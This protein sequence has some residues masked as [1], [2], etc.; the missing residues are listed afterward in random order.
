[1][2]CVASFL[3]VGTATIGLWFGPLW[4]MPGP[5]EVAAMAGAAFGGGLLLIGLSFARTALRWLLL[6]AGA[7]CVAAAGTFCFLLLR[8]PILAVELQPVVATAPEAGRRLR[9]LELD[10]T[11]HDPRTTKSGT[12]ADELIERVRE[13][14]PDVVLVNGVW[15]VLEGADL[16]QELGAA[17]GFGSAYA[18]AEGSRRLLG[19]ERGVA[20]LS[21]FPLQAVERLEA[22]P[23]DFALSRPVA[24]RAELD[25]GGGRTGAVVAAGQVG[26][27]GQD[28]EPGGDRAAQHLLL[29]AAEERDWSLLWSE[30]AS[31]VGR[32]YELASRRE[33]GPGRW[34]VDWARPDAEA[35]GFDTA[36]LERSAARIGEMQGVKGLIVL[37]H[38]ELA[39][40]RYFRDADPRRLHNLKSASKSV[41]SAIAGIAIEEGSLPL[42][43]PVAEIVGQADLADTDPRAAIEVR[44][45]LTMSSG[46]ES[47][48][49]G[50]YGR[51]VSS[52][53]WVRSAL[54][55]PLVSRP[56]EEFRY[57]TG[58][59]HLLSAAVTG[60]TGRSTLDFAREKLFE[61][62]G[63][64]RISWERDPQGIYMG[65]NNLALTPRAMARFGQLFLDRGRWGAAQVVPWRWVDRSTT[66]QTRSQWSRG[67]YGY[68]WW[69]RPDDERGAYQ[70]SGHGGQYIYVSPAWDL[71]LVV[72][73][74]EASKGRQWRRDL[75]DE[76]RRGVLGSLPAYP[77]PSEERG[78]SRERTVD[79]RWGASVAGQAS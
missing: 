19:V 35:L 30:H 54:S 7:A 78:T 2:V 12:V 49:F 59:T 31:G 6:P 64:E 37:R 71:V 41:L 17:L 58:D 61:P 48:S 20:V 68:L 76:I 46:L 52:S 11:T 29:T 3:G 42:D 10:L 25:L 36:G 16:A 32:I 24:L 28:G 43:A 21:R 14:G 47:T 40:E 73:S 39:L 55:G 70:A 51:W 34:R 79:D 75:F 45:L 69:M 44:H 27:V 57:S 26:G 1:V 13:I 62:L 18:R 9:I 74:T 63:I 67:G 33:P 4:R 53:H 23:S 5:G 38:G 50:N 72:A 77:A 60:A 65:G 66:A 8:P 56:G 15:R 22:A